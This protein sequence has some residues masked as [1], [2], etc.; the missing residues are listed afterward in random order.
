MVG[1]LRV[2]RII[3]GMTV[4]EILA[5]LKSLGDNARRAH[6]TKAGAPDN[7][8]GVKL[9]DIRAMAKK[10][11]TDHELALNLW[12]T[13]NVEAQLLATLIIKPKSLSADELDKLTRNNGATG[14][15]INNDKIGTDVNGTG[16]VGNVVDGIDLVG[17]FNNEMENDLIVY[18]GNV[19]IQGLYGS[20]TQNNF[21]VN[22]V[23]TVTV[24]GVVYGYKNGPMDFD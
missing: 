2:S 16:N 21:I 6:N 17:V 5:Q 15:F 4:N 14:D 24:N 1:L 12:D 8:F 3:V 10:I 9:G 23:F 18:N 20:N 22:D 13:G 7:Q 19:G 11:K